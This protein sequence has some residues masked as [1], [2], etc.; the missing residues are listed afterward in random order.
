MG[1]VARYVSRVNSLDAPLWYVDIGDV[2]TMGNPDRRAGA[3]VLIIEA[4][5]R[6]TA[7]LRAYVEE[8]R[9]VYRYTVK[10]PGHRPKGSPTLDYETVE[11]PDSRRELTCT[12]SYENLVVAALS[13]GEL[14]GD[15]ARSAVYCLFRTHFV[16]NDPTF[17]YLGKYATKD[18]LKSWVCSPLRKFIECSDEDVESIYDC[19]HDDN[20]DDDDDSAPQ[21]TITDVLKHV[22]EI[23]RHYE[24]L[25]ERI[26]QTIV[27]DTTLRDALIAIL[28]A[29]ESED[30]QQEQISSIISVVV[31][32][33]DVVY[34]GIVRATYKDQPLLG[35][36]ACQR[37]QR[38]AKF[39]AQILAVANDPLKPLQK[40][41]QL[42]EQRSK[43][44]LRVLRAAKA[45][46]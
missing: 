29:N 23:M 12:S 46:L 39:R 18:A 34:A 21:P 40:G 27:R 36:R 28:M 1:D 5:G 25:G 6:H 22:H 37:V 38:D 32:D 10:K 19:D 11:L 41:P 14:T 2:N 35:L 15:S 31:T 17:A 43:N 7:H 4:N 42:H 45:D 26:C 3:R 20:S 8:T 16:D 13:V 9:V 33:D 30:V 44:I 24:E